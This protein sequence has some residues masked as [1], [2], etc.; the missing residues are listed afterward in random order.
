MLTKSRKQLT[1]RFLQR[2][3]LFL[4]T[5]SGGLAVFYLFGNTQD[6]QDSTQFLI[7]MVLAGTALLTATLAFIL[8]VITVVNFI[9]RKR[10]RNFAFFFLG[11]ACFAF[12]LILTLGSHIILML[13]RGL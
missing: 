1:A 12:A 10:K 2:T 11:F 4:T 5:Y 8:S 13:A 7:L 6:F 9:A 3:V